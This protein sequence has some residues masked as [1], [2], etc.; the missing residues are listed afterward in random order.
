MEFSL[1]ELLF[2]G[3]LLFFV[4]ALSLVFRD[5]VV[6]VRVRVRMS[7]RMRRSKRCE[8]VRQQCCHDEE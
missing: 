2:M 8:R 4:S 7:V 5:F 6:R 1:L 3:K